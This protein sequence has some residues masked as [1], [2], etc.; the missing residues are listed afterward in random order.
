[1]QKQ[2]TNIQ[3]KRKERENA[4]TA[5]GKNVEREGASEIKKKN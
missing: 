3:K 4:E 1:M 2:Q 5:V